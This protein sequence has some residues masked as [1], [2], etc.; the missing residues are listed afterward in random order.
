MPNLQKLKV[1]AIW[2]RP[3]P[4][5]ATCNACWWSARNLR[6]DHPLFAQ[7]IRQ[8]QRKGCTGQCRCL[9]SLVKAADAWALPVANAD[10]Q[11]RQRIGHRAWPMW[12]RPLAAERALLPLLLDTAT[13]EAQ[14]IA[15]SLHGV[16]SAKPFC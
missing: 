6:K 8:A 14:A 15:K 7:R 5:V 11:A 12:L 16:V 10:V 1:C 2:A 4:A 3:L 13:A 9:Q